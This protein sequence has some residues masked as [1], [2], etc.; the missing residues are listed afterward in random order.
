MLAS[1]GGK[2]TSPVSPPWLQSG[3]VTLATGAALPAGATDALAEALPD[4]LAE[5]LPDALTT[6]L[7]ASGV[8]P[9]DAAPGGALLG[10]VEHAASQRHILLTSRTPRL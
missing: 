7:A 5:A 6:A 3:S 4:A 10:V 1:V 2:I 9:D 8:T